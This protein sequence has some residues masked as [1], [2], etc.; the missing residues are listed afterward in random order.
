MT[1]RRSKKG[2]VCKKRMDK[3][4]VTR[5]ARKS[6]FKKFFFIFLPIYP[7]NVLPDIRRSDQISLTR[8]HYLKGCRA[9][10]IAPSFFPKKSLSPI[11]LPKKY[12]PPFFLSKNVFAPPPHP[13]PLSIVLALVSYKFWSVPK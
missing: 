4:K 12:S 8:Y 2:L 13:H 6:F 7:I 1:L 10:L 3:M 5:E 11:F 9:T